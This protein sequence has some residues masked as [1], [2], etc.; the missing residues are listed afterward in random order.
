MSLPL[1]S[2]E[3]FTDTGGLALGLEKVGCHHLAMR[4]L[5]AERILSAGSGCD[6]TGETG[7]P[8]LPRRSRRIQFLPRREI[9]NHIYVSASRFLHP[10]RLASC[11]SLPAGHDFFFSAAISGA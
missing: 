1:N 4:Y 8:D 3:L 7:D 10:E 9:L 2:V 6:Q 5:R 11:F